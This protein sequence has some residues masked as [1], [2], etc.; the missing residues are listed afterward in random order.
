MCLALLPLLGKYSFPDPRRPRGGP[1]GG[2][3]MEAIYEDRLRV[4]GAVGFQNS[5]ND[6]AAD[7]KWAKQKFKSDLAAAR[8]RNKELKGFVF[9]T[10]VDLSPGDISQLKSHA[11]KRGLAHVA[12]FGRERLRSVLD[13][14]EGLG[15]RVQF[16]G[17]PMTLE[18]QTQFVTRFGESVAQA[19]QKQG[20]AFGRRL[21]RLEFLHDASSPIHQIDLV[22]TLREQIPIT[23]LGHFRAS[24]Q[25][26][27][28]RD[29]YVSSINMIARD[30]DSE[31]PDRFTKAFPTT[32]GVESTVWTAHET[33]K[34]KQESDYKFFRRRQTNEL[35]LGLSDIIQE[36]RL[37]LRG[38]N[39]RNI[40]LHLTQPLAIEVTRIC[41]IVNGY[42]LLRAQSD[43]FELSLAPNMLYNPEWKGELSIP[44]KKIRWVEVNLTGTDSFLDFFFQTPR[45]LV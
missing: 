33:A 16:L 18:Q 24:L 26:V 22:L 38:L 29:G 30:C 39:R 40:V 37:T 27:A 19:L 25:F 10:N 21:E 28:V 6:S 3:D 14:T 17:L 4:W 23:G 34:L 12:V 32:L 8:S 45:L 43:Q 44:E 31:L 36:H 5:A 11:E 15:Y 13:S 1:D 42:L 35:V 20:E 2:R 9:F 7:T 41:V